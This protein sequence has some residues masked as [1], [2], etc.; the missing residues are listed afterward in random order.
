MQYLVNH[1]KRNKETKLAKITED[2]SCWFNIVRLWVASNEKSSYFFS[3]V[4]GR[5]LLLFLI[6]FNYLSKN[7]QVSFHKVI[8][9]CG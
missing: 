2:E 3:C 1:A 9:A 6:R 8:C 7:N 4:L 5:A